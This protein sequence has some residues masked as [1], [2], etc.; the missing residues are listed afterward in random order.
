MDE[1]YGQPSR[2]E[3]FFT[4]VKNIYFTVSEDFFSSSPSQFN[5]EFYINA[6]LV[7]LAWTTLVV[8]ILALCVLLRPQI[9]RAYPKFSKQLILLTTAE[10]L[11]AI[12][13]GS[14]FLWLL[15]ARLALMRHFPTC[16][17]CAVLNCLLASA[18]DAA[19]S[20]RSWMVA[21]ITVVRCEAIT[22]PLGSLRRKLISTHRLKMLLVVVLTA[23]VLLSLI[24][25]FLPQFI[26]YCEVEGMADNVTNPGNSSQMQWS[27]SNLTKVR[28]LVYFLQFRGFPILI[29]AINTVV[30][31]AILLKTSPNAEKSVSNRRS[32]AVTVAMLSISF[33]IFE[34]VGCVFYVYQKFVNDSSELQEIQFVDQYLGLLNSM[35]NIIAFIFC[36]KVFRDTLIKIFR[37]CCLS[38]AFSAPTSIRTNQTAIRD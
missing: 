8:N 36:N 11:F 28:F 14:Y 33:T 17:V 13:F 6:S 24:A 25:Y 12:F 31:I 21:G 19:Q 26:I 35:A 34:G 5:A 10:I 37:S 16:S 20:G 2:S 23:S 27:S 15:I 22:R 32:A 18:L 9:Q 30:I 4:L 29:V 1:C 3:S 7:V 38:S